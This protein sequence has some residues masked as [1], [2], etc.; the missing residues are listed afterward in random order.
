MRAAFKTSKKTKMTITVLLLIFGIVMLSGCLE[1]SKQKGSGG[2]TEETT[3]SVSLLPL[4]E[5]ISSDYGIVSE[6][7][8]GLSAKRII[9]FEETHDSRA[10][11]IET[12][13]MLNRLYNNGVRIIALEGLKQGETLDVEWFHSLSDDPIKE[14]VAVGLLGDGEIS[15]AEFMALYYPDVEVIG[16]EDPKEYEVDI[17]EDAAN[18]FLF[19][20]LAI[21]ENSLSNE[22]IDQANNLIEQEDY[23]GYIDFVINADP[24]TSE[25]YKTFLEANQTNSLEDQLGIL[26]EIEEKATSSGAEIDEETESDF[27]DLKAFYQAA[28]ARSNTMVNNAIPLCS[29]SPDAPIVMII[30]AAHTDKVIDLLTDQSAAFVIISPKSLE[31]SDDKSELDSA[32]YERKNNA[33]S[34]D[35]DGLLGSYLDRRPVNYKKPPSVTG[36]TWFKSKAEMYFV[37]E[38]I[39]TAISG[40]AKEPYDFLDKF[41][42][43]DDIKVDNSSINVKDDYITFN[44]MVLDEE[45]H[46]IK[47]YVLAHHI[48]AGSTVNLEDVLKEILT[49]VT[50]SNTDDSERL[51]KITQN[52]EAMYS[53]DVEEINEELRKKMVSDT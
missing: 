8:E 49:D 26:K 15:N 46:E 30:G 32:A 44:A 18:S 7:K 25:R 28:S 38:T 16:I 34:V 14:D 23:N 4:A 36:E 31:K 19:Y 11:Q 6:Y 13:I 21:A 20:L 17:S 1:N 3:D 12:A 33:L 10:V 53:T 35:S 27:E 45:N 52:T 29:K 37:T 47:I 5:N 22:Q 43:L 51:N 40:G 42:D 39:A 48:D 24:W 50:N 9:V 2:T 41:D